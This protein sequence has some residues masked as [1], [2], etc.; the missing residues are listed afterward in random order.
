MLASKVFAAFK[1]INHG[2]ESQPICKGRNLI[3]CWKSFPF[4]LS[5]N[6][7]LSEQS[8]AW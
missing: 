5:K 6:L 4:D 3:C 8:K 1:I 7:K 2:D